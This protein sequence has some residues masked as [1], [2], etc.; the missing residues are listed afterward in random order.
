VLWLATTPCEQWPASVKAFG[1][2]TLL[3][4][5]GGAWL[6]HEHLAA[7]GIG[8]NLT[9]TYWPGAI[10]SLTTVTHLTV[11]AT[12]AVACCHNSARRSRLLSG[13][14]AAIL[15]LAVLATRGAQ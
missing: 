14:L 7:R 12:A 4:V 8:S 6:I 1:S 15:L 5:L 2:V 11:A 3:F 9:F 13:A 10:A